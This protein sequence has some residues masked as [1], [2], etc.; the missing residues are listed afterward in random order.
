LSFPLKFVVLDY[1]SNFL[2][3]RFPVYEA[4]TGLF[5]LWKRT[6]AVP[7]LSGKGRTTVFMS[8][9]GRTGEG[10]AF[11]WEFYLFLIPFF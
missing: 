10:Y 9:W 7:W 8:K 6:C 2:N 3:N 4:M 11:Y 1:R 5:A